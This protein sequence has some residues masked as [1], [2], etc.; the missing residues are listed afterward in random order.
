MESPAPMTGP[1]IQPTALATASS[2]KTCGRRSSSTASATAA[3]AAGTKAGSMHPRR[4]IT[5][6]TCH[7]WVTNAMEK[8]S[9]V[10]QVTEPT[11]TGR[12]PIRS[13]SQP[14]TM[15]ETIEHSE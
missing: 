1:A 15:P 8:T 10:E 11:R 12:R 2:P 7:A 14:P 13:A 9:T 3:R 4:S 6:P 5:T